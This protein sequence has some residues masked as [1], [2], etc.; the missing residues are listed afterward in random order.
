MLDSSLIE[1]EQSH[2][3]SFST[4]HGGLEE[5]KDQS[6]MSTPTSSSKDGKAQVASVMG[7]FAQCLWWRCIPWLLLCCYFWLEGV[8]VMG[9]WFFCFV[10][11]LEAIVHE[12]QLYILIL[13]V[14]FFEFY[15]RFRLLI[16]DL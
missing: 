10:D 15:N 13:K 8:L 11:F 1:T 9:L 6:M 12:M 4:S 7:V 3:Q 5:D 14:G 16:C 2:T